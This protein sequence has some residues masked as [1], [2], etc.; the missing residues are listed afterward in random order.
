MP[1]VSVIIPIYN[2]GDRL[3]E[4][5]ESVLNQSFQD[6][7]LLLIN[8]GSTDHSQAIIDEYQKS[9]P[10]KIHCFSQSNRG[11]SYTRNLG[12][13][14]AKGDYLSFLDADDVYHV[15]FLKETMEAVA[16]N[17]N[18]VVLTKHVKCYLQNN[19]LIYSKMKANSRDVLA[20]FIFGK[21]DANTDSWLIKKSVLTDHAIVFQEKLTY[22][23]DMLFFIEVLLH[24]NNPICID[25]ALTTYHIG[26][27][28]SLSTNSIDKIYKDIE[29]IEL[30]MKMV[31]SLCKDE[32]RKA[33][34]LSALEGYRLP[35]AVVYRLYLNK[36]IENY[37]DY[38]NELSV[39]IKKFRLNNGFRSLKLLINI[40][41][42]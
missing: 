16:D 23:E 36:S 13:K 24:S 22:G 5:I 26:I 18:D 37:K 2:K 40:W 25:K 42:L 12:V 39:Y 17:S 7:E 32:A 3:I 9:N 27:E 34:L 11:V 1:K 21:I 29:W 19:R 15:D 8:D 38:K 14:Q 28:D 35:A 31:D 33:K 41:L 20:D 10:H 30:A 4:S 6:F